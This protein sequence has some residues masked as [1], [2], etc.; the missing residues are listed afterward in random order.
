L[1]VVIEGRE[2]GLQVLRDHVIEHRTAGISGCIG[3]NR[4]RHKSPHGQQGE[5]GSARSCPQLYCSFV[6][7]ASEM[8]SRRGGGNTGTHH[9]AAAATLRCPRGGVAKSAFEILILWHGPCGCPS[10]MCR[11]LGP[12]SL[13]RNSQER[14][15][16]RPTHRLGEA[17]QEQHL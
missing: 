9:H 3:G 1:G 5:D 6:Q 15:G 4:W 11:L 10:A 2:E 17:G 8:F 16:L 14:R 13:D 7:Y 12:R